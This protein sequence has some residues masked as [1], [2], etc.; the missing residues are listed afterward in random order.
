MLNADSWMLKIAVVVAILCVRESV[1]LM[2]R[3]RGASA[4]CAG[5][6]RPEQRN[7]VVEMLDTFAL[8]IG[9]MMFIIQPGVVQAYRIPSGS[10][11]DTL[12][13]EPFNDRVLVSKAV[14]LVRN[15]QA[16]DIIVFNPPP[17]ADA[18]TGEVLIKRCVG[19]PGD[20]IEMRG[21]TLF[22][23]GKPLTE[24]YVKWSTRNYSYD[25]KIVDGKVYTRE[26]PLNAA[27]SFAAPWVQEHHARGVVVSPAPNQTYI[28]RHKPEA[29]PTGMYLMLGDHRDN[30][31]DG[32]VW[33]FVPRANVV[34]KAFCV[35]WPPTR[36][37]LLD[38]MSQP[39]HDSRVTLSH[40]ADPQMK[41]GQ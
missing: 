32:H 37:G 9:L 12:Q 13:Y 10:M 11:E 31:N 15:P 14:F 16:G 20:V 3:P 21:R 24:P 33:G 25:M 41:L 1:R 7:G 5:M 28:D 2:T 22:R 18:A 19:A 40:P 17:R 27:F 38:K 36:V 29:V 4:R 6:R 23:N 26:R 34:G 8:V 30:S 39:H 35:F